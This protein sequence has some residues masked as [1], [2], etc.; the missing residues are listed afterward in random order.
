MMRQMSRRVL[1]SAFATVCLAM[2]VAGVSG[3]MRRVPEPP[4]AYGSI[5]GVVSDAD[6]GVP[7]A[8]ATV[9]MGS[10][11]ALQTTTDGD[12]AFE[13]TSLVTGNYDIRA[14]AD[15]YVSNAATGVVVVENEVTLASIELTP[16]GEVAVLLFQEP[17]A[18]AW[19]GHDFA[20]TALDGLGHIYQVADNP[21]DFVREMA[22]PWHMVIVDEWHYTSDAML[23]VLAGYVSAGGL[24]AMASWA[25]NH[26]SSH[27]LWARLGA[28]FTGVPAP[29][30]DEPLPPVFSWGGAHDILEVPNAL[31]DFTQFY[32]MNVMEYY[33]GNETGGALALAGFDVAWPRADSAAVF[34]ANG[35][36]TIFSSFSVDFMVGPEPDHTP[37]DVDADGK[38]DAV[39]YWENQITY[40]LTH[41]DPAPVMA[42]SPATRGAAPTGRP[43]GGLASSMR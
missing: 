32:S 3:C 5:E 33:G 7:L 1:I 30:H 42:G 9:T 10:D 31:P 43:E 41:F 39:E 12:G 15:G 19:N 21:D 26:D 40:L 37:A 24:L 29:D 38:P 17:S 36:K 14:V 22:R 18:H 25:P 2:V 28:D 16:L 4:I 20:G 34:V 23:D 8:G 6:T 13:F 27:E 35:G 11:P